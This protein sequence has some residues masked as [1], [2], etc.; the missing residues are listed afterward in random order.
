MEWAS[1]IKYISSCLGRPESTLG[2]QKGTIFGLKGLIQDPIDPRKGNKGLRWVLANF[3]T[4]ENLN[5]KPW[6][7]N[8]KP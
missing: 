3:V 6:T 7:L 8:P 4:F 1:N 2:M 5:P